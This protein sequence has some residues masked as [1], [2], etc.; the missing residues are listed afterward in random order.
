MRQALLFSISMLILIVSASCRK[1]FDLQVGSGT[2]EFSKDTVFLDTVF[3]NIGSAT[4]TLKVYNKSNKDIAIPFVGLAKGEQSAYRLNVDGQAGKTFKNIPLLAKDSLY[5]FIET[6]FDVSGL[7]QN[8]FL[9][10]DSIV[11]GTSG[12]EQ[13][14]HLVTLVKDAVFLYP[15]RLADGTKET[16]PLGFD[17]EG[18]EIRVEGFYLKDEELRFTKEK[19]YVIY[20]YA[21]VAEA[22]TLTIDAGAR[23]HFHKDSGILVQ[24]G[25]SLHVNGLPSESEELMENEVI[26]EGDRLEPGYADIAGQWG[27]I[28]LAEGSMANRMEHA[29]IKNATIGILVEGNP[30]NNEPKLQLKNVQVLNSSSVNLWAINTEVKAENLVLGNAGF[31]SLYCHLG[32]RYDFK[33]ATIANYWADGFRGGP[34]LLIDNFLESPAQSAGNDLISATFTNCII[35]GNKNIELLLNKNDLYR[36]DYAF[37]NCLIAFNDVNN[38][39]S[40]NTLYDFQNGERYQNILL[41]ADAAFIAPFESNFQIGESSDAIDAGDSDTAIMVPFDIRGVDRTQNPDVGAYE[42]VLEN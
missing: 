33:H 32:G 18:N 10:T 1:D 11:F 5:V 36:F 2:L 17:E 25:G 13:E 23:I 38:L 35:D 31:S 21:T 22:K 6:T 30:N 3:S 16:I 9:Y 41:N 37:S 42:Y 24:E 15:S 34:A 39:Y 19:P 27:A 40:G 4:Y 29:T 7:S 20:G 28:W 26:F 14:V 12:N 8:E